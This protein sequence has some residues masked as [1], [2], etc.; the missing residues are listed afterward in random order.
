[1]RNLFLVPWM[2]PR[3]RTLLSVLIAAILVFSIVGVLKTSS[4][5]KDAPTEEL[6][7]GSIQK[8]RTVPKAASDDRMAAF[9]APLS[10]PQ[11]TG[12]PVQNLVRAPVPLPRSR[13]KRS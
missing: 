6:L 13:P 1:M 9:L 4:R 11:S 3:C 2:N 12:R 7:T 10:T 5:G 8:S